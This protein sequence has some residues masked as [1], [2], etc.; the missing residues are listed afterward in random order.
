[1]DIVFYTRNRCQLCIEAK[2]LLQ[3]LAEDFPIQIIEKDIDLDEE[4]TE[5]YGM[6]IPVIEVDGNVV[7]YGQI[8][9]LL[10]EAFVKE[11]IN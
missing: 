8:D 11:R 10:L 9:Y 5:K 7:Q 6:M 4:L 2:S 3:I 1:M